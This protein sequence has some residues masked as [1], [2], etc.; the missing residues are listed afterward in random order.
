MAPMWTFT[1][2]ILVSANTT[3]FQSFHIYTR[4]CNQVTSF[5]SGIKYDHNEFDEGRVV[6]SGFDAVDGGNKMGKDC[7][8]HGT[9]IASLAGGKSYGV[10]KGATLHSVRVMDCR[11]GSSTSLVTQGIYHV[12]RQV[13]AKQNSSQRTRAIINLSLIGGHSQIM[14]DAIREAVDSGILVVAAAGN[15]YTDACR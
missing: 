8:G 6:Y 12:V 1:S 15:F 14:R 5:P 7:N 4:I 11:G 3:L 9:N 2:L 13:Q 10:A